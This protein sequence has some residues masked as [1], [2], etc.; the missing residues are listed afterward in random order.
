[1][2]R[3]L[4]FSTND[5][6]AFFFPPPPPAVAAAPSPNW[7]LRIATL[8]RMHVY[9][10]TDFSAVRYIRGSRC[11]WKLFALDEIIKWK[12][13]GFK[14]VLCARAHFLVGNEATQRTAP[15]RS[16]LLHRQIL[17]ELLGTEFAPV[18]ICYRTNFTDLNVVVK[19][20]LRR[21]VFRRRSSRDNFESTK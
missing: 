8:W 1:M 6:I 3:R 10:V 14:L 15:D 18:F 12:N 21:S 7:L 2:Y 13:S 17:R 4:I 16:L 9:S 20:V 5:L 11:T 19:I